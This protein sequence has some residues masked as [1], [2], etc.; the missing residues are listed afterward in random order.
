MVSYGRTTQRA[1]VA[2]YREEHHIRFPSST[3]GETLFGVP[4]IR[5][6]NHVRFLCFS[7]FKYTSNEQNRITNMVQIIGLMIT[8]FLILL[9]G[10][11]AIT[12]Y[13]LY[14][15]T[16]ENIHLYTVWAMFAVVGGIVFL[17]AT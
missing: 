17:Y 5:D 16:G 2:T 10:L 1:S 13:S 3:L 11:S 7:F 8:V 6:K 12:Q 15:E 9:Y 14:K 4:K